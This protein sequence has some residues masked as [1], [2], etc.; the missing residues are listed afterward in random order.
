MNTDKLFSSKHIFAIEKELKVKMINLLKENSWKSIKYFLSGF[1]TCLNS[2]TLLFA[3]IK[4]KACLL[5]WGK[6]YK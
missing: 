3:L 4:F 6:T 2:N 5:F 1:G